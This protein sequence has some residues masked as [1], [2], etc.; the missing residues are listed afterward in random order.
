MKQGDHLPHKFFWEK[1]DKRKRGCSLEEGKLVH[2]PFT[3]C[4]HASTDASF[5]YLFSRRFPFPSL[6]P[7]LLGIM[8]MLVSRL[9]LPIPV[10]KN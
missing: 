1:T 3:A 6:H 5:V 8:S 10:R 4:P 2:N 9:G 7:D